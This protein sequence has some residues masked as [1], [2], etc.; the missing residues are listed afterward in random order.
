MSRK[1]LASSVQPRYDLWSRK[2]AVKLYIEF[3]LNDVASIY[4]I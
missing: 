1:L 4:I 2:L 3:Y